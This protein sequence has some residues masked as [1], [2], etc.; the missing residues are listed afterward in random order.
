MTT[1][2]AAE[3][4]K[5]APELL[6]SVEAGETVIVERNGKMIAQIVRTAARSAGPKRRV[7]LPFAPSTRRGVQLT[8]ELVAE[9]LEDEVS[10]P[11]A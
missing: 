7:P 3:F 11:V 9:I 8:A 1:V 4:A 2:S 5:R 6:R 10:G